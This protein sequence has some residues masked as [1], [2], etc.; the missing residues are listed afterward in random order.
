MADRECQGRNSLASDVFSF[1]C[2]C[3]EVK[4]YLLELVAKT[5]TISAL[6]WKHPLS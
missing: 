5:Q 3:Y 6:F 4:F 2:V 1:A